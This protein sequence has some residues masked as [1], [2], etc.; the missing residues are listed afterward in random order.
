MAAHRSA[1][2]VRR[3]PRKRP[4]FQPALSAPHRRHATFQQKTDSQ[5]VGLTLTFRL[6]NMKIAAETASDQKGMY[7]FVVRAHKVEY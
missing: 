4:A 3:R 7:E 1:A 5:H 6:I 2:D